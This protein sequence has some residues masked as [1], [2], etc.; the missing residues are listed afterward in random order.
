M[1]IERKW[2]MNKKPEGFPLLEQATLLQGYLCTRP[3][4]RIRSKECAGVKTYRLCVKGKGT[5]AR[6]EIELDLPQDKFEALARL[7]NQPLIRKDYSVFALPNGLR[8]EYS[9]VDTGLPGAFAYAEVEFKTVKAAHA[10]VPPTCL[11]REVTEEPGW[12]MA[13]YWARRAEKQERGKEV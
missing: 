12:S 10:F 7:L 5:L 3:A 4:V 1:E 9:E 11:G 8:L 6:E 2:L 13:S